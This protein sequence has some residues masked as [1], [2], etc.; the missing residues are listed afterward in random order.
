MES[1]STIDSLLERVDL[2]RPQ[3]T[4]EPEIPAAAR[5]EAERLGRLAYF[6]A[7]G[8]G[9]SEEAAQEAGRASVAANLEALVMMSP[10]AA[11]TASVYVDS[12]P[13]ED[14]VDPVGRDRSL[15]DRGALQAAGFTGLRETWYERGTRVNETGVENARKARRDWEARPE[16]NTTLEGLR[17]VVRAEH[18]MDHRVE[19]STLGMDADGL[20]ARFGST[21]LSEHALH[22][23]AQKLIAG[24]SSYFDR[25]PTHLRAV[26]VNHWVDQ[27][28]PGRELL[29]RL[30]DAQPDPKAEGERVFSDVE[31]A[32][33]R[34]CYAVV[35]KDFPTFDVDQVAEALQQGLAGTGARGTAVYDGERVSIDFGWASTVE[36]KHFVAGEVFRIGGRVS[37][38]DVGDGKLRLQATAEINLCRNLL[39]ID[40]AQVELL[41]ERHV[42]ITVAALAERFREAVIKLREG[43]APFLRRWTFCCEQD[44]VGAPFGASRA[45]TFRGA[46]AGLMAS[47]RLRVPGERPRDVLDRLTNAFLK[48]Q[49]GAVSIHD[50]SRAAVIN[51]ITRIAHECTWSNPWTT[52]ALEEQASA[53]LWA[54]AGRR[55]PAPL[56]WID[57]VEIEDRGEAAK[58]RVAQQS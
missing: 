51:A 25:C 7:L 54:P 47:K 16:L 41:A 48:D 4:T 36:P 28:L 12:V 29:V 9:K 18:R 3:A 35:G 27:A 1:T 20:L 15:E 39:I 6:R 49:S 32:A 2:P 30:R 33:A 55:E 40:T 10:P 46:A 26:N 5:A 19:V 52:D 31:R 45:E 23:L 24:G 38:S 50:V 8:E 53:L 58:A 14:V 11:T 22:Q 37:T 34:E 42:A 44:V 17:S 43:F 56:E 13:V 21:R 57:P